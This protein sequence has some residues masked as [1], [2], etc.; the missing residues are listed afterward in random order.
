[1]KVKGLFLQNSPQNCREIDPK[2]V[3]ETD[4]EI[5]PETVDK[6]VGYIEATLGRNQL[7]ANYEIS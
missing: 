5:V 6:R 3:H 4:P 7:T 1:M 2:I